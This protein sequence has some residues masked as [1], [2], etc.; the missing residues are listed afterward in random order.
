MKILKIKTNIHHLR[1]GKKRS[2]KEK[3]SWFPMLIEIIDCS[4][5][6]FPRR[7]RRRRT[8]AALKHQNSQRK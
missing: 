4:F 1:F 7:P 2:R 6:S 8:M 5:P 3:C